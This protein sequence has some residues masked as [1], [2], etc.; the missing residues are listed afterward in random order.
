LSAKHALQYS[1]IPDVRRKDLFFINYAHIEIINNLNPRTEYTGIEE[2]IEVIKNGYDE[3]SGNVYG[4]DPLYCFKKPDYKIGLIGGH[5]RLEAVAHF[6]ETISQDIHV[7]ILV[8]RETLDPENKDDFLKLYLL[9]L[10][11]NNAVPFTP[12]E[13][14]A[15]MKYL[16]DNGV[17]IQTIALQVGKSVS[18]VRNRLKLSELPEPIKEAVNNKQVTLHDA[19]ARGDAILGELSEKIVDTPKSDP[20]TLWG[21]DNPQEPKKRPYKTKR[22]VISYD[23]NKM[24]KTTGIKDAVCLPI[25]E[26]LESDKWRKDVEASGFN[27]DTIRITIEPLIKS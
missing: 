12:T 26:I 15:A 14:A 17:D 9:A 22:L 4:I 23:K 6:A 18:H 11:H 24:V 20:N 27:P 1:G 10:G 16:Y 7:P 21:A 5:R 19:I 3:K 2:L 13:E 8:H 25:E